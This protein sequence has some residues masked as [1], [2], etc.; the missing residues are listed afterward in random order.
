MPGQTEA[1]KSGEQWPL[2]WMPAFLLH[3]RTS[4]NVGAACA[5]AGVSRVTAYKARRQHSRF[6]AAWDAAFEDAVDGLEAAAWERARS[7]SDYLLWRLLASL[8]REKYAD[9]VDVTVSIRQEAAKLAQRYGLDEAEL[10]AEAEAI[11]SGKARA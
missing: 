9:R 11:V 7:H 8:R 6:R 4:A 5:V 1:E 10:I 3:F 2:A